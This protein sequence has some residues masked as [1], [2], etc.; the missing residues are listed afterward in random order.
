MRRAWHI[1]G[2]VLAALIAVVVLLGAALMVIG[3]TAGGQRLLERGVAWASHGHVLMQGLSGRFPDHL[4]LQRLQLLDGQGTW[5]QA[6]GVALDWLPLQL[7]ERRAHL[8]RLTASSVQVLRRPAYPP[9]RR[10]GGALTHL[11]VTV[12]IDQL[13][14]PRLTLGAA[15]AG[16]AVALRLQGSG[17][18]SSLQRASL[19]LRATRLDEVPATYRVETPARWRT[20][21]DCRSWVPWRCTCSCPGRA[22]LWPR[23]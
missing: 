12:Q 23:G 8:Q 13:A 5:L 18:F 17:R 1:A 21:Y 20:W 9:G 10:R 11:P 3:N 22:M 2:W 16:S 4:R 6:D 15:L 14:V 19:Q 7:L